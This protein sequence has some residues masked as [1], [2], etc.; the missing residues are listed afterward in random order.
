MLNVLIVDDSQM[1]RQYVSGYVKGLGHAVV[2]TAGSAA[3][4]IQKYKELKPDLVTM[5]ITMPELD[6]MTDGIAAVKAIISFDAQADIVMITSHGQESLV[7]QALQAGAKSYILKP[8]SEI[9]LAEAIG[10]I[11]EN[12][13]QESAAVD[14]DW[15]L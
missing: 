4:A 14:D 9:K 1:A 12:Y 5:D 8:V 15:R 11:K 3:E 13:Q 2:G 7:L 10:S 6:G